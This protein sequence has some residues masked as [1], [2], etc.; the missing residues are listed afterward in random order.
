MLFL[1]F[2]CLLNESL[3]ILLLVSPQSHIL[4]QPLPTYPRVNVQPETHSSVHCSATRRHA[5]IDLHYSL[6]FPA[7]MLAVLATVPIVKFQAFL[8]VYIDINVVFPNK[9]VVYGTLVCLRDTTCIF[10]FFFFQKVWF[11]SLACVITEVHV[12]VLSVEGS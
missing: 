8:C 9:D 5:F 6:W 4:C 1:Q 11:P 7:L 2:E 12:A 10:F 3:C